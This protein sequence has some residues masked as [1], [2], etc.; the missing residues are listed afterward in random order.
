MASQAPSTYISDIG[1]PVSEL[2]IS[3]SKGLDILPEVCYTLVMGNL[4]LGTIIG[5]VKDFWKNQRTKRILRKGF[6]LTKLTK[7]Q[8]H[9]SRMNRIISDMSGTLTEIEYQDDPPTKEQIAFLQ[10][11]YDF[12]LACDAHYEDLVRKATSEKSGD[13]YNLAMNTAMAFDGYTNFFSDSQFDVNLFGGKFKEFLNRGRK[14]VEE[15][16]GKD[17]MTDEEVNQIFLKK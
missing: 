16:T 5:N 10:K 13:Y 12:I 7:E 11:N 8:M 9:H 4:N 1:H 17:P 3:F 14:V 2:C 6:V 15:I